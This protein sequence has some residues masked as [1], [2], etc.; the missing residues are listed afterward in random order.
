LD[1]EV[2]F[3]PLRLAQVDEAVE[4][5]LP[6]PVAGEIVV[7][8]EEGLDALGEVLAHDRLEVVGGAEAALAALD[9]DDRAETALEG[10]AAAQVEAGP[11]LRVAADRI[12]RKDRHRRAGE[13]G[14]VLEVIIDGLERAVPGVAEH[15]VEPPLLRFPGEQRAADVQRL[16]E[17]GRSVLQHGQAAGDVEAA[18]HHRQTRPAELAGEIERVVEL[19]GLDTD[20]ADHGPGAAPA[21]VANDPFGDHVAIG[22]VDGD[23]VQGE[24]RPE[25]LAGGAVSGEAVQGSERVRRYQRLP[26]DDRIA[27]VVIMRRLDHD[28]VELAGPLHRPPLKAFTLRR[29]AVASS[30]L[31]SLH[32]PTASAGG[33]ALSLG[34]RLPPQPCV[35]RE[36][37]LQ[38][39]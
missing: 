33:G 4:K 37:L 17:L 15:L 14:K 22:L 13:V 2:G 38:R 30:G 27:V 28:E 12:G 21:Q 19:V 35:N 24:A 26:P 18:D 10:A 39:G 20:E 1:R 3:Q 5:I 25:H 11:V 29:L 9:V 16:L 32:Y 8:D 6:V 34:Y 36:V 7:G 23:K 31:R